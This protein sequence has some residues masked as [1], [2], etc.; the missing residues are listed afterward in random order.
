MVNRHSTSRCGVTRRKLTKEQEE[1]I[2]LSLLEVPSFRRKAGL[3]PREGGDT[4]ET[5][6][7]ILGVSR[8][9]VRLIERQAMHKLRAVCYAD[10]ELRHALEHILHITHS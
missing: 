2:A 7:R 5:L 9:A 1:A 8:E 4:C 10:P 3:P 6:G